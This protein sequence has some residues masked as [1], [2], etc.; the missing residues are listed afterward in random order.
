MYNI[1]FVTCTNKLVPHSS[2]FIFHPLLKIKFYLNYCNKDSPINIFYLVHPLKANLCLLVH[3]CM[4]IR[5]S[6]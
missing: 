6:G 4:Y 1:Y 5:A 2:A 3:T